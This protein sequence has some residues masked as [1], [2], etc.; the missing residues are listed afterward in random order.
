[1]SP[2][3]EEW[4]GAGAAIVHTNLLLA[5]SA[6]LFSKPCAATKAHQRQVGGALG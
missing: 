6:P 5:S 3:S 4:L 2:A 1:M